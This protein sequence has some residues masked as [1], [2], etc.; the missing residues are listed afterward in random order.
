M[1][2]ACG[3][4]IWADSWAFPGPATYESTSKSYRFATT[5]GQRFGM[6]PAQLA[7]L[8]ESARRAGLAEQAKKL[9][10]IA[11]A[12]KGRTACKGRL[13][14]KLKDGKYE[15]VWERHLTNG[16]APVDVLVSDSGKYV[17]T[18][19]DWH[20]VGRGP[21]VVVIYG[22]QGKLVRRLALSDF[23]KG[24]DIAGVRMTVSSTWWRSAS[25]LDEKH[26]CVVL[27]L[28]QGKDGANAAKTPRFREVRLRLATGE[29]VKD[30]ATEKSGPGPKTDG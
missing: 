9:E 22:P 14:R 12:A 10:E 8:A 1:G 6:D 25:S 23:L 17:V 30:E 18:L 28:A 29:L 24:D 27:R 4:A 7:A 15:Q 3:A 5:P 19:D 21:N 16:I 2:W 13:E 20:S 11:R 26:E